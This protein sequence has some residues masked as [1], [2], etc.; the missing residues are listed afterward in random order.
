MVQIDED[1]LPDDTPWETTSLL[2]EELKT[3]CAKR[4][5]ATHGTKYVLQKRLLK[6]Q[7]DQDTDKHFM[8]DRP[9]SHIKYL[10]MVVLRCPKPLYWQE[11]FLTS[12]LKFIIDNS[13]AAFSISR[14]IYFSDRRRCFICFGAHEAHEKYISCSACGMPMDPGCLE[15]FND[16]PRDPVQACQC[17]V[18]VYKSAWV[19]NKYYGRTQVSSAVA[20]PTPAPAPE[21]VQATSI[22]NM[23]PAASSQSVKDSA[24]PS[25]GAASSNSIQRKVPLQDSKSATKQRCQSTPLP[26]N[27]VQIWQEM[28]QARERQE[29]QPEQNKQG[30]R[31][32]QTQQTQPTQKTKQTQKKKPVQA[33]AP[34]PVITTKKISTLPNPSRVDVGGSAAAT[35]KPVTKST[36]SDK[37]SK[38]RGSS[39]AVRK[40]SD[41]PLPP[42]IKVSKGKEV[43]KTHTKAPGTENAKAVTPAVP[44]AVDKEHRRKVRDKNPTM[45]NPPGHPAGPAREPSTESNV[46]TPETIGDLTDKDS[47][48]LE[49]RLK[50]LW[51]DSNSWRGVVDH[52]VKGAK[53]GMQKLGQLEKEIEDVKARIKRMRKE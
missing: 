46:N 29:R 42:P 16:R 52:H 36:V 6:Y 31:Q 40:D 14:P 27:P 4:D 53:Y 18:C 8:E 19:V 30:P 51:E 9:C 5:L 33:Q 15:V 34:C 22:K 44:R 21:P 17:V 3:Q 25:M 43:A 38:D 48:L 41:K 7:Q 1:W 50:R 49:G 20:N 32:E 37:P 10:L 28:H 47:A 24:E 11:A 45:F 12:E 35:A 26:G 39:A 2:R 23:I 13:S